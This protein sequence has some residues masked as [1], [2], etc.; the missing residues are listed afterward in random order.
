MASNSCMEFLLF[1]ESVIGGDDD[2]NRGIVALIKV[3]CLYCARES[4]MISTLEQHDTDHS[5]ILAPAIHGL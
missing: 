4:G 5:R 1:S 2:K 3:F